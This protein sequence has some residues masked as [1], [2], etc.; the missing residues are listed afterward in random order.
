M[1]SNATNLH[2]G[3]LV[4]G[5]LSAGA[6]IGGSMTFDQLLEKMRAGTV[7]VNVHTTANPGGEIRGQIVLQ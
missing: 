4:S 7:Y 1:R 2:T 3:A 6:N 5:T